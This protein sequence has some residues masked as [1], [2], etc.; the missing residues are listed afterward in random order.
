MTRLIIFL[1]FSFAQIN[2]WAQFVVGKN[3][4]DTIIRHQFIAEAGVHYHYVNDV[5]KKI[6]DWIP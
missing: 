5:E 4:R 6:Y 3:N 2:S 1:F